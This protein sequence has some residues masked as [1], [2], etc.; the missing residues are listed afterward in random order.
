MQTVRKAV[1]A[2]AQIRIIKIGPN[3]EPS[4]LFPAA[5]RTAECPFT[6]RAG[7][8]GTRALTS[9]PVRS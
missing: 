4:R 3:I 9:L 5:F 8:S 6:N 1:A 7:Y 2:A